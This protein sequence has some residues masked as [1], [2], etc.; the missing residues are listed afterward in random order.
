MLT[1]LALLWA[2]AQQSVRVLP[3]TRRWRPLLPTA[4]PMALTHTPARLA[5]A[6]TSS[7]DKMSAPASWLTSARVPV[8]FINARIG[9][10]RTATG[11]DPDIG[12]PLACVCKIVL[13]HC[14]DKENLAWPAG[15][16]TGVI[17]Q[18]GHDRTR[19]M[20]L[21]VRTASNSYEQLPK[22]PAVQPDALRPGMCCFVRMPDSAIRSL[23]DH[24]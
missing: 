15:K 9:H 19:F 14:L 17:C 16:S 7:G 2:I 5:A 21:L 20:A 3:L 18:P 1:L 6:S 22:I 4:L 23:S 11:H 13:T 12:A 10:G 24:Q 8:R